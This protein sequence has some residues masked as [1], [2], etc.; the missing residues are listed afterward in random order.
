M[1]QLLFLLAQH[2]VHAQYWNLTVLCQSIS[3]PGNSFATVRF[4][5]LL[6]LHKSTALTIII[7]KEGARKEPV[8]ASK[9]HTFPI[10]S[11]LISQSLELTWCVVPE[12]CVCKWVSEKAEYVITVIYEL[13]APELSCSS[14]NSILSQKISLIQFST[15]SLSN[16]NAFVSMGIEKNEHDKLE[17][18]V[19]TALK[20]TWKAEEFLKT[21]STKIPKTQVFKFLEDMANLTIAVE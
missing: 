3:L 10:H 17:F 4:V 6:L 11:A 21:Q 18:V 9:H 20:K 15:R 19:I 13:A 2:A 8:W 7:A 1:F 12:G 5:Y 14:M 16:V